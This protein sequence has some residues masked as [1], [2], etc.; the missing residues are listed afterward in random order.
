MVEDGVAVGSWGTG[1]YSSDL[2]LDMRE[3]F[4]Q[5]VRAPWDGGQLR[6]WAKSAYP[7][8]D[9]PDDDEHPEVLLVLGDLFWRYGIDD[10]PTAAA[11]MHIIASGTDLAVK[12]RLGMTD[13][14]LRH[15]AKVLVDLGERLRT[16]NPKPRP[17]RVLRRPQPFILERGDCLAYPTDG[18]KLRNPYVTPAQ[19]GRFFARHSWEPDGWGAAVVLERAHEYGVFARYFVALMA[20]ALGE[21]PTAAEIGDMSILHTGTPLG[22]TGPWTERPRRCLH[23]ISISRTHL[24]RMRIDVVGRLQLDPELVRQELSGSVPGGTL[25]HSLA[26]VAHFGAIGNRLVPAHD[27]IARYLG[28]SP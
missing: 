11:A 24:R 13:S 27:P 14:D 17:R 28:G 5:V 21:R 20:D 16:V 25:D 15:R 1:L 18:G 19:E 10:E 23:W 8:F 9:D 4:A 6:A 12:R 26:N 22:L 3:D 7:A 2:A